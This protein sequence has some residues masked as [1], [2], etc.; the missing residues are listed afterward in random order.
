[1]TTYRRLGVAVL[2]SCAVFTLSGFACQGDQTKAV[3]DQPNAPADQAKPDPAKPTSAPSA[4]SDA[5][6]IKDFNDRI[7]NYMKLHERQEKGNAQQDETKDP[8]KIKAT[9]DM[10]AA[11][12]V[13][14]RAGAKHGDIFTPE[15]RQ[16]FRRL[17][18][19]ELKGPDGAET[20][21]AV[22]EDGPAP[23]KVT[24]KVNARYPE[25]QPLPTVPP[26]LLQRLPKLPESLEYRI[27]GKDLI[28]RDADANLI[29]DFIPGAI[30]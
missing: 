30:R 1:M 8:G 9:Q 15:I 29:V 12:I 20:K 25:G 6:L 5:A 13:A 24:F 23:S 16:L 17:M 11:K 26:N 22:K 4:T 7:A 18:Y 19:P 10:L 21:Q 14:A 27:I 2:F 28:L 3:G